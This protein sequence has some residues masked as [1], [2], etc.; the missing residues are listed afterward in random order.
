[1]S[2]WKRTLIVVAKF[3]SGLLVVVI[4]IF[5]ILYFLLHK[6]DVD[7]RRY[8]EHLSTDNSHTLIIDVGNPSMPYGPHTVDISVANALNKT[9]VRGQ[10]HLSNDGS[11]ISSANIE[12]RWLD[13]DNAEV[14]LRGD[15]QS[16]AV[17]SIQVSSRN[18][19]EK[20]GEC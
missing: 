7:V 8:S 10:F 3:T 2:F 12:A 14:C 13:A 20:D 17:I 16:D 1:M 5:V 19:I 15:E 9:I 6:S 11:N 18:M 4:G